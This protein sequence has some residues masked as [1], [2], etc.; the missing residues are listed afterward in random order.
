[1][2]VAVTART[3]TTNSDA[4][5]NQH[6]PVVLPGVPTDVVAAAGDTQATI[7]W[8]S[9]Q[10]GGPA[11]TYI[12]SAT[13]GGRTC[14]SSTLSCTIGGLAN[15]TTYTFSVVA[16]ND[17]GS[18]PS[19]ESSTAVTPVGLPSAPLALVAMTAPAANL[20][21]GE[22]QLTWQPP[23]TDGGAALV[24]YVVQQSPNGTD[25][26][27]LPADTSTA[28]SYVVR[29][30]AGGGTYSFRVAARN[31][32]GQ[33]PATD[34]V[35]PQSPSN[36]YPLSVAWVGSGIVSSTPSVID[37]GTT[38]DTALDQ[39]T[40]VALSAVPASGWTFAGW[41]GACGGDTACS[42][43]MD[44]AKSVTA[45]FT[46]NRYELSVSRVDLRA[47]CLRRRRG[48]TV[49]RRARQRSITARPS[50]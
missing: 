10:T 21:A 17:A 14:E 29:G 34:I 18:G 32:F 26:V 28:A 47:R 7:T 13:P 48:S 49:A 8:A 31:S 1:M 12:V 2:R 9:P 3:E 45:T 15:G 19:S 16:T 36:R 35:T 5:L 20:G 40:F 50:C 42:V 38:C 33:G 6:G 39:G 44:A 27:T 23:T 30:L 4:V 24:D 41:S 25:W 11:Q 46:L 37:C 43:T 22:V